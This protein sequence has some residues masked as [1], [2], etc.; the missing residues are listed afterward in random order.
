MP[1][2]RTRNRD[3]RYRSHSRVGLTLTVIAAPPRSPTPHAVELHEFTTRNCGVIRATRARATRPNHGFEP[4]ADQRRVARPADTPR[5]PPDPTESGN[6]RSSWHHGRSRR[7]HHSAILNQC[8]DLHCCRRCHHSRWTKY[9]IFRW[10]GNCSKRRS[11]SSNW[12]CS[13]Q[14]RRTISLPLQI[15]DRRFSQMMIHG[16]HYRRNTRRC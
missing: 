3:R 6:H 2:S 5:E 1:A 15:L 13:E 14:R 9:G 4:S 7:P 8:H 11:S 16:K 12:K 10:S